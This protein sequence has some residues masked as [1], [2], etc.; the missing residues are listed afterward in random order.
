MASDLNTS[1]SRKLNAFR[2][3]PACYAAA[4][5]RAVLSAFGRI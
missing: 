2:L 3:A 4:R 5:M 1:G